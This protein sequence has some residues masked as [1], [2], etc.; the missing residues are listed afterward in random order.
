MPPKHFDFWPTG[1]PHALASPATNLFYNAEVSARRYPDK[2]FIVFFESEVT[3][4]QFKDEVERLAGFLQQDCALEKGDRVLL[5]MQNSPQFIISYYAILRANAIV[6]PI[7]PM[8]VTSELSH[9][10]QDSGAHM[11]LIA[12]EAYPQLKPLVGER[13]K[14]VIVAAY[15]DYANRATNLR[16]PEAVAAPRQDITDRRVT[17]WA[18]ALALA[19]RPGALT[20]GPDDLCVIPYSSGTTGR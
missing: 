6:V 17:L 1:L 10:V 3:F 15:G 2:P 16:M 19:R 12:Q 11:A 9:Y 18:D 8:S 5:A 4:G 20:M 7:N 14:H 13:L